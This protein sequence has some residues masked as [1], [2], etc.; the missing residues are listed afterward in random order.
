[1][2]HKRTHTSK[3][4]QSFHTRFLQYES[5]VNLITILPRNNSPLGMINQCHLVKVLSSGFIIMK[6]L[7]FYVAKLKNCYIASTSELII[8]KFISFPVI[9]L[10]IYPSIKSKYPSEPECF[11]HVSMDSFILNRHITGIL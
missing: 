10:P 1:M 11:S 4:K 7:F 5:P 8:L 9:S 3:I 2:K 6:P